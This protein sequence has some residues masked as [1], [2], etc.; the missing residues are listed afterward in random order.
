[1]RVAFDGNLSAG[2]YRIARPDRVQNTPDAPPSQKR[3]GAA[4][5]INGVKRIQCKRLLIQRADHS[6]CIG[7]HHI[8][9]G[10]DGIEI[11]VRTF[12]LAERDMDIQSVAGHDAFSFP[13]CLLP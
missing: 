5:E 4:S 9:A 1:M 12:A 10:F 8:R 6:G 11:T 13:C 3:R 2:G 7:F